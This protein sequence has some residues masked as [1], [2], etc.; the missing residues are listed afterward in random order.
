LSITF[1]W[2]D[3]HRWALI[4]GALL[5]SMTAGFLGS[6][7]WPRTD[8]VAKAILNVVAVSCLIALAPS[9]SR[10]DRALSEGR[11]PATEV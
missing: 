5:V 3:I 6:S 9:I 2:R 8:V 10:R 7:T 11:A 4:F 1:G